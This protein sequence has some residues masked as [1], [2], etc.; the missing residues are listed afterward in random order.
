LRRT[1]IR[2]GTENETHDFA[3]VFL[4]RSDALRLRNRGLAIHILSTNGEPGVSADELIESSVDGNGQ[5]GAAITKINPRGW[6][7]GKYVHFPWNKRPHFDRVEMVI[8]H[9]HR[10]RP[11]PPPRYTGKERAPE[12]GNDYFGAEY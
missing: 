8:A 4:R 7:D 5:L 6:Y 1:P 12:S 9:R 11:A 2:N 10:E 3:V